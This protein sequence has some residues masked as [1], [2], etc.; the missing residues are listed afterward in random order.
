MT[1]QREYIQPQW[2]FDSINAGILLPYHEYHKSKIST[3]EKFT[4]PRYSPSAKLP[5]H[6]SPFVDDIKAGYV[7]K[8]REH[9]DELIQQHKEEEEEEGDDNEEEDDDED[10]EV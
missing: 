6:L 9:L 2:I 10:D 3:W 4:K 5:P 7:P 8:Q 1:I